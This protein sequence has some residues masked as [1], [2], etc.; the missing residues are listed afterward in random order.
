MD[1]H[2]FW[3]PGLSLKFS[4]ILEPT[5]NAFNFS[6]LVKQYREFPG[7]L[8]VRTWHFHYHDAGF[9]SWLGN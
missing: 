9:N 5:Q 6:Y 8:V 1:S 7:S 3:V 4:N 2:L